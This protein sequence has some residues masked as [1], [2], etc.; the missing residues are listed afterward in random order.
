M[1]AGLAG[2]LWVGRYSIA[3]TELAAGYELTVVAA[4]VIGGVS[5][6]GGIGTVAG[7]ALGVLFIGVVNS[8]LWVG[9]VAPFWRQAISG[10]VI[11][12]SVT[13][14]AGVQWRAVRQILQPQAADPRGLAWRYGAFGSACCWP[15]W[16]CCSCSSAACSRA[17]STPRTWP[18][19]A[20]TS[21]KKGCSH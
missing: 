7:A 15:C 16:C 19:A 8:A 14:N 5:I 9:Q 2:L 12:V 11:L 6:G 17:S 4:C 3:Y 20:S 21:P 18:T 10:A 13:L 1:L